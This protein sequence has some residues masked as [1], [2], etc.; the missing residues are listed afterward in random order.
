VIARGGVDQDLPN[1]AVKTKEARPIPISE[2]FKRR[3]L[4]M[5]L[6]SVVLFHFGNAPMLPMF[7]LGLLCRFSVTRP[8]FLL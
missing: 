1:E 7:A 3:E 5:F 8:V 4:L 2:L 6:V